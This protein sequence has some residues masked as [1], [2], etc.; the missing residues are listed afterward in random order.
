[1]NVADLRN[2]FE[3]DRFVGEQG[4]GHAGE[5]G[6]FRSAYANGAEERRA[7]ADY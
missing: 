1:L 4:G 2:V 6:V 7:S 3:D 5:R